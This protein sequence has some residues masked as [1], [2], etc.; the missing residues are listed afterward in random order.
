VIAGLVLFLALPLAIGA[1]VYGLRRWAALS[2]LLSVGTALAL[3]TAIVVLPL[4]RTVELWGRQIVMGGTVTFLGRELVLE[5][6]DRIAIAFLYLTAAGIFAL[7]WRVSPGAMLFPIGLGILSLLSGSLL[8]R[9]LIYAALLVELAVVLSILALQIEGSPPTQGGLQYISFALLAMPG[10]LVIHWLMDRYALTPDDTGLL[11]ASAILLALSFALL[12]GSI[13]FHMW[14]PS[15]ASGGEPLAGAFVFTVNNGAV[16]FLLLAYLESYPDLTTYARF[17]PVASGVGMTMVVVGGLFA[18]SQ[19]SLGRLVGY[20]AFIDSG[21]ALIAL[22]M[23]SELGLALAFLSLLARPFGLAL[24]AAGHKGLLRG[25]GPDDRLDALR[26]LGWEAPWSTLAFLVGGLS[27]AGL[28][29]GVGFAGRWALYRALAPS[30]LPAVLMMM[31]AS[32]GVMVG[33]G[34]ALATLFWRAQSSDGESSDKERNVPS[35][36]MLTATLIALAVAA[37]V[38]VGLFPQFLAPTALRLAGLYTFLA[39]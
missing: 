16:W 18:A 34:R 15:I 30:D 20:G 7:T 13:P 17:A 28:P 24:M 11:E 21:V 31:L 10:L 8:I 1:V 22:G 19:R 32:V 25:R 38:G 4:G 37:C 9:P 39:P 2:A 23:E 33:V 27:T 6:V 26:G 3:G 14:M 35:E 12:L 36:G 5:E 29:I